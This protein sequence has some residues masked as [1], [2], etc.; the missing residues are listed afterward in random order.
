MTEQ[1]G[2]SS[3]RLVFVVAAV[4][5]L[6]ILVT[7][8]TLALARTRE[9]ALTQQRHDLDAVAHM[10]DR[11]IAQSF[12]KI[13]VVLRLVAREHNRLAALPQDYANA[14]LKAML[15][16]IPES[17]SLRI[18]DQA[19]RFRIDAS[20]N[21]PETVIADRAYFLQHK[22]NPDS[23][24]VFSEPIFARITNNWVITLSRRLSNPDGSFAGHVQ[25]AINA[26]DFRRLFTEISRPPEG[27]I[28]LLDSQG[29]LVARDPQ[30]PE[31]LGRTLA[32]TPAQIAIRD[33]VKA[34]HYNN[35][36][37]V[38]GVQRVLSLQRVGEYP[39][40]VVVAASEHQALKAW[41]EKAWT[42]GT[43]IGFLILLLAALVFVWQRSYSLAC[44]MAATMRSAFENAERQSRQLL[45]SV[46][47]P[48]WLRDTAGCYIAVNSA[49]LRLCGKPR[50]E[51]I[52][53]KL[54]DVWP[55]RMAATF[56]A[57]DAKIIA[58]GVLERDAGSQRS[59]DGKLRH[60]EYELTPLRDEFGGI[61]SIAGFAR[62]V[63]ERQEA[64]ERVLFLVGHDTLTALPN[65]V[66]LQSTMA[67][68][69]A[70]GRGRNT[71]IALL[72]L[73]VDHFK[74]INDML[75]PGGG[76]RIL[77]EIAGRLKAAVLEKDTVSRQGGDEFAILLNDCGSTAMVAVIAERILDAL[78]SPLLLDGCEIEL[79]ASIG[80]SVYPD[81]G[82][83]V[84]TLL[85]N[86]DAALYT[87]KAAGRDSYR[88]FEPAMN[89]AIAERMRLEHDLRQAL[90]RQELFLNYQPQYDALSGRMV[91]V[92]ALIRWRHP[93]DGMIP[94]SRFIPIAEETGLII[95][96]GEW[97]LEEACR[98][99]AAWQAEGCGPL[100]VAVNLSALQLALPSLPA[101][102]SAVLER[103]GLDPLLLELEITESVL[104]HDTDRA[105]RVLGELREI[106]IKISIDDFGTGYSSL[107]YLKRLPLDTLKID[108]SFVRDLPDDSN[109]V[110]IT[111]AIIAISSKLGLAVIAEGVET[112]AQYEFLRANGCN[113]VQ[114]FYFSRPRPP[115]EIPEAFNRGAQVN[116]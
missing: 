36:S 80:I 12:A 88:F 64:A 35:P 62:D 10:F 82:D 50:E 61:V 23:G 2:F 96:I 1:Q 95:N 109:D 81:D 113:Q 71:L 91:G 53:K 25:A 60:Y 21:I 45:D 46:P 28:S 115:E 83:D 8:L 70:E 13:D 39:F 3:K 5:T 98:Q 110:A 44:K 29:R 108:Q 63:T 99:N 17:Q 92:E 69:V 97:V 14:E 54:E 75:G 11:Q 37:P 49:Y 7:V 9:S 32:E 93:Q 33:G 26:D 105:L 27:S 103:N 89:A 90:A 20:G 104:M 59:A 34:G 55:A 78:R 41:R 72:L 111:Q 19:G 58:T 94:P 114:G 66:A 40:Y 31:L 76:D 6:A 87:V 107:N 84:D 101:K 116:P 102:V 57:R 42:Y 48:A 100:T 79:T 77:L 30:V 4:A 67:H 38:D 106:G 56:F 112:Q 47:D 73:D 16:T 52:G 51:V 68:A 85:K 43:S 86:A 65:R 24:L 15:E 74:D 18:V 22:N